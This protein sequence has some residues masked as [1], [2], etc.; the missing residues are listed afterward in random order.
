MIPLRIIRLLLA[1]GLL[2]LAAAACS[3]NPPMASPDGGEGTA[4]QAG[5][6]PTASPFRPADPTVTVPVIT[7]WLSPTL[8]PTLRQPIETLVRQAVGRVEV[9]PQAELARVRAEPDAQMVLSHW[10]YA[11]VA[12]F[13][14]VQDAVASSELRAAWRGGGRYFLE[15]STNQAW[16][17]RW[18]PPGEGVVTIA[19]SSDLL[20]LAW[21]ARPAL[22]I[23]P[24]EAL[25][26]RWKVLE[27]DGL[28]PIRRSFDPSFYSLTI[29]FGLSGDPQAVAEL[30]EML[31]AA[32]GWPESNR[33]PDRLTVVLMKWPLRK[34][35][36]LPIQPPPACASAVTRATPP[37]CRMSA[38]T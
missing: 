29:P 24:F 4:G 22:A 30:E 26:P 35:V 1:A 36:R 6:A 28:S 27:V 37:C 31:A 5:R 3:P 15:E 38:S 32:G 25:E 18:G 14:T 10:I 21:A 12:P 23:V 16:T 11:L 8:P 13:S 17:T 20:D 33:D 19:P 34:T 2:S 7:V 9:V